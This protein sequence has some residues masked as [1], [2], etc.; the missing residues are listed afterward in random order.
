MSGQ[1]QKTRPQGTLGR[2]RPRTPTRKR[3]TG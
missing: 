1:T 2:L 3:T